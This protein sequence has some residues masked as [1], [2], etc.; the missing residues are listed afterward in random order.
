MNENDSKITESR[1]SAG[2]SIITSQVHGFDHTVHEHMHGAWS[3][4][5]RQRTHAGMMG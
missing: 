4:H 1:P 5:A 2:L 3:E